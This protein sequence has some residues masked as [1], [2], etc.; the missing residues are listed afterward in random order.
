MNENE[1]RNLIDLDTKLIIQPRFTAVKYKNEE[2][3][4]KKGKVYL[5]LGRY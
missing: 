5:I 1:L 2:G 3:K 4:L